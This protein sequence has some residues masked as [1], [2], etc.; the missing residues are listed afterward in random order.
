MVVYFVQSTLD[1]S[2]NFFV[3]FGLQ[4]ETS[5]EDDHHEQGSGPVYMDPRLDAGVTE[6]EEMKKDETVEGPRRAAGLPMK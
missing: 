1:M 2:V 6:K 5:S 4:E 3:P